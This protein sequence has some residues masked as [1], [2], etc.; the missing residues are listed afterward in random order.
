MSWVPVKSSCHVQVQLREYGNIINQLPLH[1]ASLYVE[2]SRVKSCV[3]AL[4]CVDLG[5]QPD[6]C[7]ADL[8]SLAFSH[9]TA[10]CGKEPQECYTDMFSR[11]LV[12]AD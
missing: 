6:I 2:A 1:T 11:I 7:V 8:C 5:Q 10:W 12:S 9:P 3:Q 4:L